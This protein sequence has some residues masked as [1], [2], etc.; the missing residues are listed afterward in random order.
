MGRKHSGWIEIHL[1]GNERP[2]VE[3]W[4]EQ[5][6]TEKEIALHSR[7]SS[8]KEVVIFLWD[9]WISVST[10]GSNPPHKAKKLCQ[11]IQ[12]WRRRT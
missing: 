3:R 10:P 8:I 4:K 9:I 1:R 11:I 7:S 6:V 5:C 12:E 2:E